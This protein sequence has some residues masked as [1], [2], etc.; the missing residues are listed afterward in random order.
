MRRDR[1]RIPRLGLH[2]DWRKYYGSHSPVISSSNGQVSL[3]ISAR[4]SHRK[5]ITGRVWGAAGWLDGQQVEG[6]IVAGCYRQHNR[7]QHTRRGFFGANQFPPIVIVSPCQPS[8]GRHQ[9]TGGFPP[10]TRPTCHQLICPMASPRVCLKHGQ[11]AQNQL[12]ELTE[13]SVTTARF[14]EEVVRGKEGDKSD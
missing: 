11:C 14:A 5:C 12:D 4:V 2:G 9:C 3:F 7:N 6:R 13:F 1:M 8:K 10:N